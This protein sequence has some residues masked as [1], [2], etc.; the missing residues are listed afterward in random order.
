MDFQDY[1]WNDPTRDA[2]RSMTA[3]RLDSLHDSYLNAADESI[4][5]YREIAQALYHRDVPYVLLMHVGAFDAHMLPELIA[6]FRSR[7]FTFIITLQQAM[8]DPIYSIDPNV[9]SPAGN[10]FN[11]M[12]AQSRNVDTPDMT[13][14]TKELDAM[15][16]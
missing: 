8:A 4:R 5:V 1:N 15:C 11:E 12:V 6:L 10:T 3:Q 7:G 9:T 13:D 2:P 14:R 16:R